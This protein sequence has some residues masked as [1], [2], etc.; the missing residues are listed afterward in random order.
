MSPQEKAE[1][2][3][4]FAPQR[5]QSPSIAPASSEEAHNSADSWLAAAIHTYVHA[6][7]EPILAEELSEKFKTPVRVLKKHLMALKGKG[8]IKYNRYTRE[9]TPLEKDLEKFDH[10][11]DPLNLNEYY[12]S[13]LRKMIDHSKAL[14]QKTAAYSSYLILPSESIEQVNAIL[15][16]AF[17]KIRTINQD[18]DSP[19]VSYISL[20]SLPLSDP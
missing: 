2:E 17:Q 8:A 16:E 14:S 13:K 11:E 15:K 20:T 10:S 1:L 5:A 6:R 3:L 9:I 12:P 4:A 19:V 18:A 7:G